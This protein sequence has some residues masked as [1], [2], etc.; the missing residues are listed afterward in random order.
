MV[1][2]LWKVLS[3]FEIETIYVQNK[4][5]PIWNVLVAAARHNFYFDGERSLFP[6]WFSGS[7]AAWD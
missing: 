3:S 7:T 4:S 1:E 2:K 5:C 6:V